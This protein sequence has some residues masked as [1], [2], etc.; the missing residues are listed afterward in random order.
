MARGGQRFDPFYVSLSFFVFV[1]AFLL[2]K[3]KAQHILLAVGSAMILYAVLN[4]NIVNE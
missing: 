3:R 1:I 2:Y 4:G